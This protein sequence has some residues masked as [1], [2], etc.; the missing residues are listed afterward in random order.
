MYR[1]GDE[2]DDAVDRYA[3]PKD[4]YQ[5]RATL[6]GSVQGRSIQFVLCTDTS[7][8]GTRLGPQ[9]HYEP[10]LT[11]AQ[12]VYY[13]FDVSSGHDYIIQVLL[14]GSDHTN[15]RQWSQKLLPDQHVPAPH[16]QSICLCL[17]LFASQLHHAFY[18][19]LQVGI[20]LIAKKQ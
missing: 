2:H 6:S 19:T 13:A 1:I 15:A 7:V 17:V 14:S 10:T 11:V 16:L 4:V 18:I 3:T 5:T 12:P 20:R 8:A 9:R